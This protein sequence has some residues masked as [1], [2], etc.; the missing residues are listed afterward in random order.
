MFKTNKISV[1]GAGFVGSAVTF[2]LTE[3]GIASDIVLVDI[4]K[5]K[6]E[7]EAMDISHGAAFVRTVD[8]RAGA[9]P[10][11]K[12]SDLVIITAGAGQKEGET[13]LDLI[14][15]NVKIFKEMIPQ[16]VKYSPDAILLVVSNPVDVLSYVTWKLS[17]LSSDHVLGSGTVLDSS[18]LRHILSER[19]D[20][21]A[22]NVHAHIMGEHGDSE[23]PMWSAASIGSMRLDYFAKEHNYHLEDIKEEVT[24]EVKNSA[25]QIIE[26]KG[27]TNYAVSL[28]VRRIAEAILRDEHS[29]LSVSSYDEKENIYYSAPTVIGRDGKHYTVIPEMNEEEKIHLEKTIKIMKEAIEKTGL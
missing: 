4:N 3:S 7:G 11:T 5:D 2:S 21:D 17:G 18:R 6:G 23:F 1:I 25:Y 9:Y 16:I 13:R 22:R 15:K 24:K 29:I 19:F 14:E 8:L 12:N 20:I 26:K 10:E 28:A 27:Y